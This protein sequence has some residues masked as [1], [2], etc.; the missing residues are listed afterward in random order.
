MAFIKIKGVQIPYGNEYDV[1]FNNIVKGEG[2]GISTGRAFAEFI[3]T[4]AKIS[5][6]FPH[7]TRAQYKAM[8]DLLY[9]DLSLDPSGY[10]FSVEYIDPRDSSGTRTSNFYVS[11]IKS[12]TFKYNI[13]TEE[14]EWNNVAFNLIEQ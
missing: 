10:F 7:L 2:R 14:I 1:E 3:A 11:P 8:L 6:K 9:P 13:S 12:G 5:V 4:K